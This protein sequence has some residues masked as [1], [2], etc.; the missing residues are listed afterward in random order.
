MKDKIYEAIKKH[1]DSLYSTD[2]DIMGLALA[3]SQAINPYDEVVRDSLE[4]ALTNLCDDNLDGAQGDNLEPTEEELEQWI[5]DIRDNDGAD[6]TL[7]IFGDVQEH[8]NSYVYAQQK[9]ASRKKEARTVEVPVTSVEVSSIDFKAILDD[10][11]RG[12][13]HMGGG[14]IDMHVVEKTRA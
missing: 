11:Q 13:V 5:R 8:C 2:E 6:N 10:P 14:D 4:V 9:E 7:G 1:S 12:T 3:I